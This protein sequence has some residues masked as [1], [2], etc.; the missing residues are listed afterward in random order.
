MFE[1]VKLEDPSDTY[2]KNYIHMMDDKSRIAEL[3]INVG[4]AFPGDIADDE[5]YIIENL[6]GSSVMRTDTSGNEIDREEYY[7]FGDSSLRTFTYKRY[8]YVGKERDQESG[9]YY[10]GA[11]YYA[12]W[13][14]RFISVDPLAGKYNWQSSYVHADNN[15][16]NKIDHR[17]EGT[18]GDGDKGKGANTRVPSD[19]EIKENPNIKIPKI[20]W[21]TETAPDNT[22]IQVLS[23]SKVEY[24]NEGS[25]KGKVKSFT[26]TYKSEYVQGEGYVTYTQKWEA[27]YGPKT[28]AFLGYYDS[29]AKAWY[30]PELITTDQKKAFGALWNNSLKNGIEN[31]IFL[32]K[33]G[34]YVVTPNPGNHAGETW[35]VLNYYTKI[36]NNKS[37]L[38]IGGK[39][40]EVLAAGHTHPVYLPG[41][42]DAN[43]IG[44][45]MHAGD[46]SAAQRMPY[47]FHF[48]I[49]KSGMFDMGKVIQPGTYNSVSTKGVNRDDLIT[50]KTNFI[51]FIKNAKIIYPK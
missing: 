10:Y 26:S 7:P 44:P 13:T 30:T 1:Y 34:S 2:E 35:S 8:R 28:G 51:N 47:A 5:V 29:N 39:W 6:I 27:L 22:E 33:N 16:I 21:K 25:N 36:E 12:A 31:G 24:Y 40:E 45:G 9:L 18:E 20:H 42:L 38:Y 3:R 15:P 41:S 50:G 23:T 49:E 19:K 46:Q 37:F 14:C 32:L 17:G 11:R 48:V 4:A 43:G